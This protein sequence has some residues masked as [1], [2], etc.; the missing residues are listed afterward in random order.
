MVFFTS[1]AALAL[2][3]AGVTIRA[4]PVPQVVQPYKTLE[5]GMF[6][7]IFPDGSATL[8]GTGGVADTAYIPTGTGTGSKATGPAG[9]FVSLPYVTVT[10]TV[11]QPAAQN[12]AASAS[13]DPNATQGAKVGPGGDP[14]MGVTDPTTPAGIFGPATGVPDPATTPAGVFGPGT[15]VS[16]PTTMPVGIFGPTTGVPEPMS[17]P[18]NTFGAGTGAGSPLS[19]ADG[20]SPPAT[21]PD[22]I[23]WTGAGAGT[24]G[25]VATGTG[26]GEEVPTP[27]ADPGLP[28][29]ST[30]LFPALSPTQENASSAT[31]HSTLIGTDPAAPS[32]T[33]SL[34]PVPT[35]EA[36]FGNSSMPIF[37]TPTEGFPSASMTTSHPPSQ[38]IIAAVID[39]ISTIIVGRRGKSHDRS[40]P[41]GSDK[42]ADVLNPQIK[43]RAHPR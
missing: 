39:P 25:A 10:V 36:P 5:I 6:S 14:S 19:T 3:L 11:T 22:G 20:V 35:G 21:T 24:S 1:R 15:G 27:S 34:P 41:S 32:G 43:Q 7:G 33:F 28:I 17:T 16:E 18:A 30:T 37:V 4:V 42:P 40:V 38:T 8:T 9:V 13:P 31:Q 26:V 23:F 2:L 12:C 29:A